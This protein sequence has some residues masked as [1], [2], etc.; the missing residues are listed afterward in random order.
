MPMVC[1][2][3]PLLVEQLGS[4]KV[5]YSATVLKLTERYRQQLS[6]RGG[7]LAWDCIAVGVG[8]AAHARTHDAAAAAAAAASVSA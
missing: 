2:A 5:S 7:Q 6:Q 4:E 3:E 1:G 8:G